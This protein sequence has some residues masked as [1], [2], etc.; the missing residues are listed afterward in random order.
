MKFYQLLVF[1]ILAISLYDNLVEAKP[2]KKGKSK[3]EKE[4]DKLKNLVKDQKMR[5]KSANCV[6]MEDER[7]LV[8]C[9][10][11]HVSR[12]CFVEA[13]GSNGL[14]LGEAMTDG[15]ENKFNNCYKRET[16]TTIS[17]S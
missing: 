13:F 12:K 10:Y 6:E 8:N 2:K 14:E 9:I 15:A 11:F 4:K 17:Q 5:A 7:L 1:I 16:D 3:K